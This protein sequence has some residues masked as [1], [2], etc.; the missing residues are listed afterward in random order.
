MANPKARR[1]FAKEVVR[2][3]RDAGF[4]ALWAGGC[5]RDLLMGLSPADYDVATDAKPDQ[6]MRILPYKALTMGVSFGVV[7]VRHPR[8]RGN[9]VEIATF[10]S[11][12]EYLDGRHPSGIVFSTPQA[13]AERRDFT[14][15]GMFMDPLE[16]RVIDYVGGRADLEARVL[17]AIGDPAARFE[18]DRLRLLRAARFASR[19]DLRI[20]PKT[21]EAIQAMAGQVISVSAERIGEELRRMLT[22]RNR[23]IAMRM[24]MDLGLIRAILPEMAAIRGVFPASSNQTNGDLW[25]HALRVLALL[26]ESPSFT[27]AFAALIQDVGAA[28]RPPGHEEKDPDRTGGARADEIARRLRFSNA[29]RARVAWLVAQHRSLVGAKGLR[30]SALKRLLASPGIDELLALHRADALA[31]TGEAQH[32]DFCERYLR[33]QPDGPINPPPLLTGADLKSH[34][35]KPGAQFKIILE[36]LRDAQLERRVNDKQEAIAWLDRA[37]ADGTFSAPA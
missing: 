30:E 35:L 2:R 32:V 33:D 10:R 5:V 29:E 18:E 9:E 15:N 4:Q 13:D 11:D 8:I 20:E 24:A 22:H 14:I 19:F 26:P 21:L 36:Q 17:R 34:G 6:V 25:D 27:L 7:R 3:L 23:A 28:D 16:D 31:R 37:L 12:L 1:D